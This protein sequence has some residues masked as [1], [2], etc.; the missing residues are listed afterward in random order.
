[1]LVVLLDLGLLEAG[2]DLWPGVVQPLIGIKLLDDS[3]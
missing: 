3:L 1:V 2:F